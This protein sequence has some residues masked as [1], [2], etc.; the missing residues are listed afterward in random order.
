ME[1]FENDSVFELLQRSIDGDRAATERLCERLR[2]RLRR[3]A[4]GRLPPWARDG[5]DTDDL[6]QEAMMRTLAEPG[7]LAARPDFQ[8]YIRETILNAIRDQLRRMARRHGVAREVEPVA[9]EAS[10]LEAAL[11]REKMARF[12]TALARLSPEDREAIVCRVE[13]GM[14]YREIAESTGRPSADAARMAVARAIVRLSAELDH[15]P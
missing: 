8:A 15:E 6:V 4:S 10:P 2:P 7:R 5:I 11:G 13:F 9:G 14:S 1:A 3:W 12:E